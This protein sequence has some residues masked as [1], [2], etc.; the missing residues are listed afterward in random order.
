LAQHSAQGFG[1]GHAGCLQAFAP[2]HPLEKHP[3]RATFG[4]TSEPNSAAR[5]TVV[6]IRRIVMPFPNIKSSAT[7]RTGLAVEAQGR[8]FLQN[9]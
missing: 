5:A 8:G 2:P 1:F 6:R 3:A 4:R 7:K 9:N